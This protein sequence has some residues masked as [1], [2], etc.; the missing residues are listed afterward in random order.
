MIQVGATRDLAP[1]RSGFRSWAMRILPL[2][3]YALSCCVAISSCAGPWAQATHVLIEPLPCSKLSAQADVVEATTCVA[4]RCQPQEG[5]TIILTVTRAE[6]RSTYEATLAT[7][8]CQRPAD[9]RFIARFVGSDGT[10]THVGVPVALLTSGRYVIV[11]RSVDTQQSSGG[12]GVIK[13]G[14]PW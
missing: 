3:S 10:Q 2:S 7:G 9:Q 1:E 5:S 4:N 8:S 6:P 12:C 11:L 13:R 14:W